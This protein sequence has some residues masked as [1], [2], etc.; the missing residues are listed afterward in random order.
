MKSFLIVLLFIV[1]ACVQPNESSQSSLAA[2]SNPDCSRWPGHCAAYKG[3]LVFFK[4]LVAGGMSV[5]AK[6][7]KGFSPLHY[8]VAGKQKEVLQYLIDNGADI[9]APTTCGELPFTWAIHHDDA[10]MYKFLMMEGA[11]LNLKGCQGTDVEIAK[12]V[13]AFTVLQFM[14]SIQRVTGGGEVP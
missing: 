6:E 8:A 2:F 4:E 5:D 9:N 1:T 10:D 12:A 11:D 14:K 13:N 7:D 3:D